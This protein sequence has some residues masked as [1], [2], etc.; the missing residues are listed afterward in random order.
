M[1]IW[2]SKVVFCLNYIILSMLCLTF[3]SLTVENRRLSQ[4]V[5]E[6]HVGKMQKG[7]NLRPLE[8]VQLLRAQ[9][10]VH[11]WFEFTLSTS[12]VSSHK[13]GSKFFVLFLFL[14][15]LMM[16]QWNINLPLATFFIVDQ[17][18]HNCGILPHRDTRLVLIGVH[19]LRILRPQVAQTWSTY[20]IYPINRKNRRWK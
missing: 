1:L 13:S 8:E 4:Q 5:S 12:H 20:P 17:K 2:S 6:V 7:Y 19:F 15:T 10:R 9:V 14:F 16:F 18:S 3:F 11:S